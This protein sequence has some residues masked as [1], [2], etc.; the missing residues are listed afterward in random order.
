[1]NYHILDSSVEKEF[2][3]LVQLAAKALHAPVAAIIF[4]DASRQWVKAKKG[5]HFCELG[6]DISVCSYTI[7][8]DELLEVEDLRQD[9]RFS[10][11]PYVVQDPS[12][13]YYAGVPLV[14]ER[15]F[16]FG[17]FYIIDT[18]VRRLDEDERMMLTM[19]A[20]QAMKQ[21][22]LRLRNLQ[23][24]SLNETQKQISSRLSHDIKNPLS[25][26]RM[27]LDMKEGRD[28]ALP[29]EEVNR[30][31][32]MLAKQVDGT[33]EMLNNMINWG[34]LQLQ[35]D[36]DK[37]Q[38]TNIRQLVNDVISELALD[39]NQKQNVFVNAIPAFV[40]AHVDCDGMR[41]VLRNLLTN[42]NKFTAK[43]DITISYE[44][45]DGKDFIHVV[46]TGVGMSKEQTD[47]LHKNKQIDFSYG[48][49]NE[50]GNGLALGLLYDYFAQ[51]DG[52]F[53]FES[54]IVGSGTKVSFTL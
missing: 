42:A 23:L 18:V 32:G 45:S 36:K 52:Q 40:K 17:V 38:Y 33:I 53:Y 31:N 25:N 37:L 5:L 19:L 10:Q 43:G 30:M 22:E 24:E 28:S 44:N 9:D 20:K 13:R 12:Y 50:K 4:M 15:G 51:H 7:M 41:F 11:F 35:G 34:K 16:K 26:I 47:N 29:R 27:L 49:N 48:T 54:E 3:D 6:R 21:V 46:D 39:S 2:D 8:Q 1:L 14:T